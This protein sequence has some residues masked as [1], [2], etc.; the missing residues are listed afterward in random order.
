MK[1]KKSTKSQT[2]LT[3]LFDNISY[4]PGLKTEWGYC[5]VIETGS[6][7]VLFD[8][9]SNGKIL[10]QNM[11]Q[12]QVDPHSITSV[13]IGLFSSLELN[14]ASGPSII[15]A[16]LVLFILSLISFNKSS[17]LQK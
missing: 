10:L 3:V 14:T 15:V 2:T 11:K 4:S 12:L 9:G 1:N 6:D 17:A 7:T 16:A 13:I 8:T 5:C